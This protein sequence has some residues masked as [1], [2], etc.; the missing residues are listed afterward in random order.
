MKKRCVVL[1][2]FLLYL[3]SNFTVKTER[4]EIKSEK[5]SDPVKIVQITDLHGAVFGKD[6]SYLLRLIKKEA[7]D[8]VAVTGDAYTR[9]DEKGKERAISLLEDIALNY[10]VYYVNGE[11]DNDLGFKNAL[12]NVGVTVLDYGDEV[13]TVGKTE[14]HL[15]GISNVYYS[16]TFDLENAFARD[17]NRFSVLLAH[18][19]NFESF[20]AFGIDLALCGDSH[21]GIFRL[22]FV[23]AI[24]D[25]TSWFP[26]YTKGLFS[27]GK[28]HMYVSSG[29]GNYPV[30]MR[31]FNRP[32]ISV[33]TLLSE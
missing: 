29:L 16:E 22:P 10:R 33:I 12:S 31:F 24:F 18:M 13:F 27:F 8:L 28:T 23:G 17:E 26:K 15:Y 2:I 9:G 19:Q 1:L 7:P 3:Y 14:I 4:V 6:N 32:E 21:G 11:H 30:A 25:G 20:E 5:I